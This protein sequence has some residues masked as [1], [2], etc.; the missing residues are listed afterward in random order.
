MSRCAKLGKSGEALAERYLLGLGYRLLHRSY[1]TRLG[2]IDLV[3][4]DGET[5]VFVEVKTRSAVGGFG[6]PEEA[7]DARKRLRISRA[8]ASFLQRAGLQDALVRFDVVTVLGAE[9]RHIPDA[10]GAS[11]I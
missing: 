2:E 8:A 1:R 9:I 7:V 5:V 3:M 4:K 11:K 6:K 10:F